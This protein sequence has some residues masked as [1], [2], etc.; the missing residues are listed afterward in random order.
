MKIRQLKM[1]SI[2]NVRLLK[3][4]FI[5]NSSIGRKYDA[6]QK[7]ITTLGITKESTFNHGVSAKQTAANTLTSIRYVLFLSILCMK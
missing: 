5:S 1:N 7:S 4:K 3:K 6:A 2:L